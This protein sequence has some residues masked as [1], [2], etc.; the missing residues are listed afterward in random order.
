MMNMGFQEDVEKIMGKVK[1]VSDPQF[2][3]F[4]ATMPAWVR[5]VADKYYKDGHKYF[6]LASDLKNKT[7]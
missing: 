7:S 5:N 2:I 4:S 3:M 6:D 1:E